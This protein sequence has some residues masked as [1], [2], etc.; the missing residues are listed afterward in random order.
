LSLKDLGNEAS[1]FQ[2]AERLAAAYDRIGREVTSTVNS[3]LSTIL[4]HISQFRSRIQT[5]ETEVKSF[6]RKLQDGLNRVVLGFERLKDFKI[7]VVTDFEQ[8]D[9]MGKLKLL[10]EVVLQ[11]RDT[12]RAAY[13][14]T[15]PPAS[16][17]YALQDFMSVLSN[18]TL[19]VDLAQHITLSGSV[20]DNGIIKVFRRGSELE[21]LSSTGLTAIALITLLSGML[22]VIRGSEPIYIPWVT[23]EV[24]RFDSGNFQTLMQM[25]RENHI[26]VVTASPSLT[27]AGYE[28]FSHRYLFGE[29]GS[30]A[31]YADTRI[32]KITSSQTEA[33]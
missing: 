32:P 25:L 17:A 26:D 4:M 20:N 24:G 14:F 18:G 10:D 8:L 27:P 23:D 2:R 30:I 22:N 16:S 21:S 11:H 28:H 5:F 3:E 19:E 33:A 6:N 31:V 15:V 1:V 9:F 7:S 12:P 29:R 13:S